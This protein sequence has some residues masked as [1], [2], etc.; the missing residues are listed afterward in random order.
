M[1]LA[2]T[3]DETC[4]PHRFKTARVSLVAVVGLVDAG[5]LARLPAARLSLGAGPYP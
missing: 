3:I 1:S 2:S 4:P 5:T